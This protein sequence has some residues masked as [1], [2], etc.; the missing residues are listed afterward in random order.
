MKAP[1]LGHRDEAT[2][3]EDFAIDPHF[4]S[5]AET[6]A[7]YNSISGCDTVFKLPRQGS[8]TTT[9]WEVNDG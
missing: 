5:I 8:K 6:F 2:H 3:V 9:S 7:F 1:Q 4:A